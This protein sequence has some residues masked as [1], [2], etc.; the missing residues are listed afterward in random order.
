MIGS[1]V[2]GE[3]G[4]DEVAARERGGEDE[5]DLRAAE[6]LE[7]PI[8]I[9]MLPRHIVGGGSGIEDK[10]ANGGRSAEPADFA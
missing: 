8:G 9:E 1:I 7:R 4:D 10:A 5:F 2:H 6:T 3:K